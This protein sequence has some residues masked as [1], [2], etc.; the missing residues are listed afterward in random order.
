[1]SAQQI[2]RT[3][4]HGARIR[5]STDSSV[6]VAR[7]GRRAYDCDTDYCDPLRRLDGARIERR[8]DSKLA[9]ANGVFIFRRSCNNAC[10]SHRTRCA[11]ACENTAQLTP[12]WSRVPRQRVG[13]RDLAY[14]YEGAPPGAGCLVG[15]SLLACFLSADPDRTALSAHCSSST[16]GTGRLLARCGRYAGG[17][18]HADLV[19][20]CCTTRRCRSE[21]SVADRI[22]TCVPG[23]RSDRPVWRCAH[24]AQERQ[25]AQRS[26]HAYVQSWVAGVP[27]GR[28][29][30]LEP[31]D[32]RNIPGRYVAQQFCG[33]WHIPSL[34]SRLSC[35]SPVRLHQ[36]V[37]LQPM[38]RQPPRSTCSPIS[39]SSSV[40]GCC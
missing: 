17:R 3:L 8:R 34:L 9:G 36:P 35:N 16:R 28:P 11:R 24:C 12:L 39:A 5:C 27:R 19:L 31:D 2:G 23:W 15:G 1:M 26:P 32:E 20:Q 18:G 4:C 7:L 13:E 6:L 14:L 37:S 38:V 25:L 33:S 29:W 22:V 21:R 10:V 30:I 40:L